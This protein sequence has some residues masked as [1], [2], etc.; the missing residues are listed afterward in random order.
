MRD[1]N[2]GIRGA[3]SASE[4]WL[5]SKSDYDKLKATRVVIKMDFIIIKL[6]Y[7]ETFN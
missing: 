2:Y 5:S 7:I 4:V 6:I 3:E 1:I